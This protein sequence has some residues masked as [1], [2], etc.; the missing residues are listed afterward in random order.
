MSIYYPGKE[1]SWHS[2][3][4]RRPKSTYKYIFIYISIPIDVFC[5]FILSPWKPPQ[6]HQLQKNFLTTQGKHCSPC[7]TAPH[8]AFGTV[9]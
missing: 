2:S 4:T 9:I 6:Q 3:F 5:N 7:Y 8:L 1:N